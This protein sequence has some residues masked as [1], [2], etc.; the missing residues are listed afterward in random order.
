MRRDVEALAALAAA[1][2]AAVAVAAAAV[3]VV[4]TNGVWK[5]SL[6]T[7]MT[8]PS[9]SSYDLSM[10]GDSSAVFVMPSPL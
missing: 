3:T 9:W 8:L 4:V 7:V 5:R 2:A 10:E 1:A 6:S